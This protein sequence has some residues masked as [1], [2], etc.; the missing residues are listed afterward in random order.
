MNLPV[1]FGAYADTGHLIAERGQTDFE[2]D[3][4]IGF[5]KPTKLYIVHHAQNRKRPVAALLADGV[6]NQLSRQL[7]EG[8]H[9][10]HTGHHRKPGEVVLKEFLVGRPRFVTRRPLSHLKGVDTI[11][12][13]PPH[14]RSNPPR[15]QDSVLSRALTNMVPKHV[16]SKKNQFRYTLGTMTILIAALL[17]GC[18]KLAPDM[19]DL[20]TTTIPYEHPDLADS[21]TV[22]ESFDT[23]LL[24]PDGKPSRVHV[25][26]QPTGEAPSAAAI[27][28][29][30][31]AFDYVVEKGTSGPLSGPHYHVEPRLT[32]E[33]SV[34]K[35]WETLGLQTSDI[36]PAERNRG[37]LTAVLANRGVIQFLPGNCWGDMWHNEAGAQDNDVDEEGFVR[38]GRTLAKWTLRVAT[39]AD[40]AAS[41][42]IEGLTAPSDTPVYLMGLGS[43]GRGVLELLRDSE[44]P[45]IAGA[46]IDSVPDDL[47]AYTLNPVDFRDEIAGLELIF[48]SDSLD[49]IADQSL[50]IGDDLLP[51]R[52]AYLWSSGNPQIPA[53][54]MRPAAEALNG[55]IGVRVNDIRE[56]QHVISNSDRIIAE[57]TVR[58]LMD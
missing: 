35:V 57:D 53:D 28:M 36:D 10:Q 15:A 45:D 48:G 50:A 44:T 18:F 55:V 5:D 29:H 33:F 34:R 38:N 32:Q 25:V 26:Y 11:N 7:R 39:D 9:D 51:P 47:S 1:H 13:Q 30:S 8:F 41:Q 27:V 54:A 14:A 58:F 52:V 42:G 19:A 56:A 46:L 40:F 22:I 4:N 43:G 17:S 31:G 6:A 49:T 24:C 3:S 37:A 16:W 21:D 12:Q 23:E 2:V 20:D